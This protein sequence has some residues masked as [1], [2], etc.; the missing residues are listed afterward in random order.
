MT[1]DIPQVR[2]GKFYPGELEKGLR[3]E[4]ALTLAL[5]EMYVQGDIHALGSCHHRV[6]VRHAFLAKR[7]QDCAAR[8]RSAGRLNS[9]MKYWKHGTI[10]RWEK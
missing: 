1:F 8:S 7:R 9:W 2:K 10:S 5:A 6:F 3:S 4:H